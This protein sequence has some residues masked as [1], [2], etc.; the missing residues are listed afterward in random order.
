MPWLALLL[1][2]ALAVTLG[3]IFP[4]RQILAQNR[5]VELT[6]TKLQALQQENRLLEEQIA[7]LETPAELERLARE[8]LGVVRP[9]EIAY[10]VELTE[11]PTPSPQPVVL[12][13]EAESPGLFQRIWDFLTG[14]D[15]VPDE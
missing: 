10:T 8:E 14:R 9:N 7:L 15:L 2:V 3:G 11:E 4:F 6:R 13:D 12:A 5:Q 1:L